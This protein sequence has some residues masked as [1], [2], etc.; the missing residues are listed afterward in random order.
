MEW[1]VERTKSFDKWWKRGKVND[2]N[3]RYHKKALENFKNISLPH[4]VQ[5]CH[6]R[7]T[8]FECWATRLPD[9]V[10]KQGK[11]KG[12]RIIFVLDIEEKILWLQGIFRRTNLRYKGQNGKY[13]TAYGEL[14]KNLATEFVETRF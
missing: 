7:N 2:S 8:S 6:F 11:S 4:D 1:R 13:D 3:Y 9:K 10:R 12:F 5:I 14:V